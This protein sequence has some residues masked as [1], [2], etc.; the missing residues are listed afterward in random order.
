MQETTNI[1]QNSTQR[2]QSLNLEQSDIKGEDITL[3][4]ES[5]SQ[6]AKG[7]PSLKRIAEFVGLAE[8]A[9]AAINI[10]K[11]FLGIGKEKNVFSD[12][13]VNGSEQFKEILKNI[14]FYIDTLNDPSSEPQAKETVRGQLKN[15]FIQMKGLLV[16]EQDRYQF[17]GSDQQK[18]LKKSIEAVDNILKQI[19]NPDYIPPSLSKSEPTQNTPNPVISA[20]SNNTL[21]EKNSPS[22]QTQRTS[23]NPVTPLQAYEQ[24]SYTLERA[25]FTPTNTTPKMRDGYIA[26][27]LQ[28]EEY[29]NEFITQALVDGSPELNQL[30]E[31]QGPIVA[32]QG[33]QDR[34]TLANDLI[35]KQQPL[36]EA[37]IQTEQ[38]LV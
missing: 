11:D 10:V 32:A 15:Q 28:Q 18:Q 34:L 27:G 36:Q 17:K 24:I 30:N 38:A 14:D 12:L 23:E 3:E 21:V 1:R 20:I 31:E 13:S 33:L 29:G 4:S 7:L 5:S 16:N 9:E 2:L 22:E 6:V 19:D 35:A 8:G 25:G 26:Y 37:A